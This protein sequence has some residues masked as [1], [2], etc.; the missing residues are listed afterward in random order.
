MKD[1]TTFQVVCDGYDLT[2]ISTRTCKVPMQT[3]LDAPFSFAQGHAIKVRVTAANAL[4]EGTESYI[5]ETVNAE[6][7]T[8]PH[9]PAQPVYVD[10]INTNSQQ[11][12]LR[13]HALTGEFNGGSEIELYSVQWD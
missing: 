2:V 5:S 9:K 8:T 13:W 6:V 3:F 12:A 10:Q 4:G 11:I 7:A 1:A